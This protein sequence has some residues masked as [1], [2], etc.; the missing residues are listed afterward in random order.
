[1]THMQNVVGGARR[2]L[3]PR[4]A[5]Q[6]GQALVETAVTLPLILLV[7][8]GIFEFG[9]AYQTTQILTNAAREGARVAILP[10]ATTADVQARVTAYLRD[11]QLGNAAN[12]TVAVNQNT[13]MALG[14]TT[15]ASASVVT[16]NY[17]FS[18]I[19]LNP[20]VKLVVRGSTVG[21]APFTMSASAQ[22]RNEAQ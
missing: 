12:A 21:A 7:A 11:G 9:R 20:V 3:R 8:V 14:G 5:N 17:P 1:M 4:L 22:M 13:T 10:D 6:R 19:V 2:K 18:F 16:V 15:T